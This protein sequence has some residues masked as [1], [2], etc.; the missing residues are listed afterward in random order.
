MDIFILDDSPIRLAAFK[1]HLNGE[2]TTAQTAS[3]A[4]QILSQRDFDYIY[5][6]HDLG[7][8]PPCYYGVNC[9]PDHP[10]T[11]SEVIRWMIQNPKPYNVV[12]HTR[13]SVIA[14]KMAK[15]LLT[16]KGVTVFEIPFHDL[17]DKWGEFGIV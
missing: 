6:D 4:I 17:A 16:I 9:D 15:N 12:I 7:G 11:G 2:I 14:P 3:E 8:T 13:N 10:N 5:L 1:R